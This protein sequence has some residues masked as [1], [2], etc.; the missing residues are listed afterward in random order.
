MTQHRWTRRFA[1]S[2]LRRFSR[3]SIAMMAGRRMIR[4]GVNHRRHFVSAL[5][6]QRFLQNSGGLRVAFFMPGS[7]CSDK[8]IPALVKTLDCRLVDVRPDLA[9]I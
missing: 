8:H 1:L 3:M 7:I 5:G 4:C 6:Y 9:G 2:S